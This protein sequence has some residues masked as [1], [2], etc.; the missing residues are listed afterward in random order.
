MKRSR[1]R[2]AVSDRA[3]RTGQGKWDLAE[4]SGALDRDYATI[5]VLGRGAF[6]EVNLVRHRETK[7]F[8]V[9]KFCCKLDAPSQSHLRT[10]A[11]LSYFLLHIPSIPPRL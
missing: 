10:E 4:A 1:E 8:A 5:G 3:A 6:S 7:Q 11:D 9:L 2:E